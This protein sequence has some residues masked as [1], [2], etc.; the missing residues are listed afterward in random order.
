M[1]FEEAALHIAPLQP[2]LIKPPYTTASAS[3]A[4]DGRIL[5]ELTRTSQPLSARPSIV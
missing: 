1:L 3:A 5:T 4:T 2:L